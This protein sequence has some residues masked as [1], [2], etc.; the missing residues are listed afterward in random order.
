[1]NFVKTTISE[2]EDIVMSTYCTPMF[3]SHLRSVSV[4]SR[5]RFG[6]EKPTATRLFC[7]AGLLIIY[8]V[9]GTLF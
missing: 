5:K 7:K 9:K 8:V 2:K 1:M 4:K 3:A 6:P